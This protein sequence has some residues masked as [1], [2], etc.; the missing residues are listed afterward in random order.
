MAVGK[1]KLDP[2]RHPELEVKT[3]RLPDLEGPP[4]NA[5]NAIGREALAE[6]RRQQQERL[7]ARDAESRSESAVESEEASEP[8]EPELQP[9]TAAELQA[10]R[11]AA[12]DEGLREGRE[13]GYEAGR[14]EGR[15][16]GHKEGYEAGY[17][18]G[19]SEGRSAGE[20]E[21]QAELEK[22]KQALNKRFA[23]IIARVQEAESALETELTP[24]VRD[25]VL[26]LTQGLVVQNLQ[27]NPEQIEQIAHKAIQLLPSQR[28]R[29]RIF[30]H[31]EDY[32]LLKI[33]DVHWL[34]QVSLHADDTLSPGGCRLSS[35][36]SL[37]DYTLD[38]RYQQQISALLEWPDAELPPE[39]LRRFRLEEFQQWVQSLS[40]AEKPAP[41]ANE[42]AGR[43]TPPDEGTG[44]EQGQSVER[45]EESNDLAEPDESGEAAQPEAST[46]ES[47]PAPD[48]STDTEPDDD[49]GN[50][51]DAPVDDG[52]PDAEENTPTD[53]TESDD[54][55]AR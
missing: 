28:Q 36:H 49:I 50:R 39:S 46:A 48:P 53:D 31:P 3:W 2:G 8:E 21:A 24:V 22:E 15:D 11:D 44:G 10:I 23:A 47:E 38:N 1:S 37:L 29:T 55:D 40:E 30:L 32:S 25:L 19:E 26:H 33:Q 20:A 9:P 34:E 5:E 27:Q 43:E 35:D 4:V 16:A 51:A 6:A 41:L 17:T 13:T 54:D 18:A 7:K 14:T 42:D 12:R 52:D 45:E